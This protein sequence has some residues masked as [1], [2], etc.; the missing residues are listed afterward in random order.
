MEYLLFFNE[1]D[2]NMTGYVGGKG[3]NLGNMTRAGLPVPPGFCLTTRVYDEFAFGLEL[4]RLSG[5]EART[6]LRQRSL[7]DQCIKRMEEALQKFPEGTQFSVRSSAT[8]EDLPYAS[9]AGQQD[10]Y[11]NVKGADLAE[12]VKN[13]FVSLYTDRAVSY[14][15][16]NGIK[17]PKMSVVVQQ[18][19]RADASGVMFTVD[20]VSGRRTRLV[21]DAVFGLGEAIVSGQVS[22]DHIVY[23]KK[24]GKIVSEDIAC[25]EF[26]VRPLPDGGTVHEELHTTEP[27]LSKDQIGELASLGK[28][29]EI[30]YGTPQ[31][32]EWA[33]QDG[34]LFVLQT[35]PITSLYPVPE[36]NDGKFHF[37]FNMGYQQMN[38]KAMP[39][40]ALDCLNGVTNIAN[41]ELQDY[42]SVLFYAIGQH[43][44]MDLSLFFSAKPLRKLLLK[45]VSPKIDPLVASAIE[46]LLSRKEKLP[47]LK[48]V[49]LRFYKKIFSGFPKYLRYK[50]PK[51]LA[52]ETMKGIKDKSDAAIAEMQ[53]VKSE[54]QALRTIFKNLSHVYMFTFSFVPM[55]Y[56]G[57]I[58]LKRLEKLEKKMG[59][60][61][62]WTQVIQIGNEGN[63]VTEMG[64]HLGDL[65]DFV[66]SDGE[67]RKLMTEGGENLAERLLARDDAFGDCY[68][69]FMELY[70]FRGP[71]ELDISQP[72]WK[73][74]PQPLIAQIL[75]MAKNKEPGSHR[76]EY[77]EKK[78]KAEEQGKEMIRAVEQQFGKKK[79]E[80]AQKL[81]DQFRYY[82]SQREHFKYFWMRIFGAVRE[83]LLK[84]GEVLASNGQIEK[85][86]DIM[87]L[88]MLEVAYALESKKDLK[89]LIEERKVEFERISRLSPPRI[90][91]TE[92]EV[93]MGGLSRKG[94]PENALVGAGVSAGCVDGI[95]KVVVDP[96]NAVVEKGEI[97]VAP[98]TDP[99]W[100]PL[101]VDAA[102]IVTEIG[103]PLTHGAVVAREYGIPGVVGVV[104]ATKKLKT[105]QKIRVD[106]TKGYVLPLEDE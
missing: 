20:P 59:C 34:H 9:F 84:I 89:E 52:Q 10:T 58:A 103:G 78:Q 29:L 31:D 7:S 85:K 42:K 28:L 41:A 48:L 97:L 87:H 95:A 8:A 24:N 65:A 2:K 3:A 14:R 90:L 56:T 57:L 45:K 44:F 47:H 71:G 23:D 104:D 21:I 82:Y 101:F 92:G 51:A 67:L 18:M 12:A 38:T 73:E 54:P 40:M 80:K 46:E 75:A 49:I 16:K 81:H 32:V 15:R 53:S 11:L 37:F 69:R 64:L 68:R 6:L 86:E 25:K 43:W 76:V 91:T 50:D 88:H 74:N 13:C 102:A 39:K 100:S 33:F 17:N 5:E 36:V 93:L 70:G 26:A 30:H 62:K 83:Q 94:L 61:G 4:D 1:I 63:I 35:R 60:P 106:G 105:G 79:A 96:H 99:G 72:R 19:V 22:P 77:L 27:V 98:F 66:V 55:L